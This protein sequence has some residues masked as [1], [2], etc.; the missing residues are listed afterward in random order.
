MVTFGVCI[1]AYNAEKT[2]ASAIN[3]AIAKM[4]PADEI[5]VVNDGTTARRTRSP[6]TSPT[7]ENGSG[8]L[9]RKIA[10]YQ[11]RKPPLCAL[12]HQTTQ[13]SWTPMTNGYAGHSQ[14]FARAAGS[15]I[16]TTLAWITV[17]GARR[18]RYYQQPF[19]AP[20]DQPVEFLPRNF[21]SRAATVRRA[22]LLAL[23]GFGACT[24]KETTKHG[25]G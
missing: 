9:R 4:R 20:M 13:S 16:V 24:I 2:V 6:R 11:Q 22:D 7:M 12:L 18:R 21:I 19:P 8:H 23:G 1:A 25:E 5:I 15:A 17:Q 3:S 10:A 14:Q